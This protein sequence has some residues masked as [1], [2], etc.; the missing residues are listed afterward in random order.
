MKSLTR[1]S[2]LGFEWVPAMDSKD[3]SQ[4]TTPDDKA[5]CLLMFKKTKSI[6]LVQYGTVAIGNF[7][8]IYTAYN[9]L[10][11]SYINYKL[12]L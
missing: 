8:D 1:L 12:G 4:F 2:D 3:V 7:D 11:K 10:Y 5:P 6:L 9:V